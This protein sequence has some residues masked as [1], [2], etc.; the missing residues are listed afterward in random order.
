VTAAKKKSV[1]KKKVSKRKPTAKKKQTARQKAAAL[2]RMQKAGPKP[3]LG[4]PNL[5]KPDLKNKNRNQRNWRTFFETLAATRNATRA[6]QEAGISRITAYKWRQRPGP[7]GDRIRQLWDEALSV[8]L[9]VLEAEARRRATEGV[10]RLR[11]DRRGDALVDPRTG[12][13]YKE[14]EFSDTLLIFL[15]KAYDPARFDRDKR[16]HLSS[17]HTERRELIVDVRA[18]IDERAR[19]IAQAVLSRT[20]GGDDGKGRGDPRRDRLGKPVHTA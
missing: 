4:N 19:A 7:M 2:R 8:N 3:K 16:M 11:F 15:L 12:K 9:D 6:A 1:V 10:E 18:S 20:E 5:Q 14:K 17:D 13:V